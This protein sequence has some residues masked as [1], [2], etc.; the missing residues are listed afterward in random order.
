MWLTTALQHCC[1]PITSGNLPFLLVFTLL[2]SQRDLTLPLD[3][4][5]HLTSH[6]HPQ[7]AAC[8][9]DYFIRLSVRTRI[10]W[11]L[12]RMWF[13]KKNIPPYVWTR[14]HFKDLE[15]SGNTY[16]SAAG[17][18]IGVTW[19]PNPL[20]ANKFPGRGSWNWKKTQQH[21]T[22][23]VGGKVNEVQV[24]LMRAGQTISDRN[25]DRKQEVRAFIS[26]FACLKKLNKKKF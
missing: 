12:E 5:I 24:E 6:D 20:G 8:G 23:S 4:P 19:R 21:R 22:Q 14:F 18:E 9:W 2:I 26:L 3:L 16:R 15:A 1:C 25:K 13:F 10:T 17:E 7:T 11:K